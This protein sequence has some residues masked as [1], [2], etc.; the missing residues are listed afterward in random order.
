MNLVS[1]RNTELRAHQ[2]RSAVR[3][4]ATLQARLMWRDASGAMRFAS[5]TTRDVSDVDLFVECQGPLS[6]PLFRLVHVQLERGQGD[7]GS[8]PAS[9]RRHERVLAAVYRV[10]P[11]KPSTGAPDGYGLRLLV[12]PAAA[13]AMATPQFHYAVA[14]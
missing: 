4:R 10:G 9:L 1:S 12:E 11:R 2:P 6:I 7:V 14:N 3:R 13:A 8:A 5:A